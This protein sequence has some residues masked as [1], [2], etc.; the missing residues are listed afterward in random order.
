MHEGEFRRRLIA[1]VLDDVAI[2][3]AI[4]IEQ[5]TAS[6]LNSD[7]AGVGHACS[8]KHGGPL[9]CVVPIGR[10]FVREQ[11]VEYLNERFVWLRTE[12]QVALADDVRGDRVDPH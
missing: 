11:L 7:T 3:L 10:T 9:G 1:G 12:Q 8:C 5:E 4:G 6:N 2:R